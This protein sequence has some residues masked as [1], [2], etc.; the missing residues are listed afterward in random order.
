MPIIRYSYQNL[1]LKNIKD[2]SWKDIPGLE[3][4]FM[5]SNFG[6]VKRLEYELPFKDGRVYIKE[7]MIIKPTL[8]K[9]PNCF[10]GDQTHFLRTTL[11]L[12]GTT[13]N[14]S[15][16]RMVYHLF[17]SSID[18]ENY[19]LLVIAK[20]GNGTNIRPSNLLLVT[21]SKRQKIIIKRNRHENILLRPE[22]RKV[23]FEYY[24]AA[25]S[26]TVSQYD[27]EG[28]RLKVFSSIPEAAKSIGKSPSS[29]SG[30]IRGRK[31][32][33][34]GYVWRYGDRLNIDLKAYLEKRKTSSK[35]FDGKKLSQYN[36][37]GNRIAVYR[38]IMEAER[39]TGIGSTTIGRVMLEKAKS[40]GGFYW[41]KGI[42]KKKIDLSGYS[43]GMGSG[44]KQS[45]R[46]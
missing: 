2:E 14:F 13:Y 44:I 15:I 33:A 12:G 10:V 25:V 31:V 19:D 6:R 3:G 42:G 4:Y 26:T 21:R 30:V 43:Y 27:M 39:E 24:K 36:M 37:Q 1:S 20:D 40:A 22:V 7:Q 41:K 11:N 45:K 23:A 8:I 32:T 29:I 17:I 5:I 18:F 38:S 28:K 35:N 46:K 34:G 16:G 9:N